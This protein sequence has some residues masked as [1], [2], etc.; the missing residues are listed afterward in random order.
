[1]KTTHHIILDDSQNKF[2]ILYKR[3][4]FTSNDLLDHK[5][6]KFHPH[7]TYS[8]S[9]LFFIPFNSIKME[10][11]EI[12]VTIFGSRGVG[13]STMIARC[14]PIMCP[15]CVFRDTAAK[16]ASEAK[17]Q[18]PSEDELKEKSRVWENRTL[19]WCLIHFLGSGIT[20]NSLEHCNHHWTKEFEMVLPK[21]YFNE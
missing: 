20:S 15:Y 13:K 11:S 9:H 19:S 18:P 17:D 4:N 12:L 1:M 21:Y 5:S 8:A 3:E 14:E 6:S 7:K 16:L 10:N 2:Q